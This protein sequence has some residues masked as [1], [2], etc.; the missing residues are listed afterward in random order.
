MVIRISKAPLAARTAAA[1]ERLL[2]ESEA[3]LA[4]H[5]KARGYRTA[6]VP[7]GHLVL[8]KVPGLTVAGIQD[9]ESRGHTVVTHDPTFGPMGAGCYGN[10]GAALGVAETA[11][12]ATLTGHRAVAI[13]GID[14]ANAA[15]LY[16]A[17]LEGVAVISAIC[18]APDPGAAT[19]RLADLMHGQ[20]AAQMNP[21]RAGPTQR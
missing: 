15:A 14:A 1:V 3:T 16:A 12:L 21:Q 9:A 20:R 7:D 17:G 4:T 2:P 11:R 8:V 18:S 10:D 19:R 13:G 5:L 6:A